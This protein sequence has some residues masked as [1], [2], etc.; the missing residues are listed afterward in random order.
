[1]A[2]KQLPEIINYKSTMLVNRDGTTVDVIDA[3]TGRW[4]VA[5][6]MRAAKWNASVW[7]RLNNEF[8]AVQLAHN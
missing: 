4:F 2:P 1:M 3:S 8:K 6:S 5:K 7:T